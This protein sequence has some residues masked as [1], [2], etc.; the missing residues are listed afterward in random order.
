ML[1]VLNN[2]HFN[3]CSV[4]VTSLLSTIALFTST[5]ISLPTTVIDVITFSNHEQLFLNF[6]I[7][8]IKRLQAI[9]SIVQFSTLSGLPH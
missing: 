6:M 7:Q 8:M 9:L 1:T 3:F 2:L 5:D 4:K